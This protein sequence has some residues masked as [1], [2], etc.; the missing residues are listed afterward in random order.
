M[1]PYKVPT[2]VFCIWMVKLD[3]SE[4]AGTGVNIALS[5]PV[6]SS[7][8]AYG[9][10]PERG[11]DGNGN[12]VWSENTCIM[13]E[14]TAADPYS[15]WQVNV[16]ALHIFESVAVTN[17]GDAFQWRLYNFTVSVYAD[18]PST[19]PTTEG[20]VCAVYPG[21]VGAGVREEIM[22][23]PCV[24]GQYLRIQKNQMLPDDALQFCEMEV[25]GTPTTPMVPSSRG[26]ISIAYLEHH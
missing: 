24:K 15:W 14:A 6:S 18:D 8:T 2:V 26:L 22:C 5:K 17:R 11:N 1:L 20:K 3:T 10:A 9:G 4:S 16:Q 13:A 23:A 19:T 25:L 21:T 12:T 7:N